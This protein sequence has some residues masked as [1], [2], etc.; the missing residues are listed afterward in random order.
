MQDPP[1]EGQLGSMF[2]TQVLG[3]KRGGEDALRCV[4]SELLGVLS[5]KRLEEGRLRST[6][7]VEV[8]GREA[9]K[10]LDT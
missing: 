5:P 7:L 6:F 10:E 2:L 8:G 1:T 3:G 4:G 9:R